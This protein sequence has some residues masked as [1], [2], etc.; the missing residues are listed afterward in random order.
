M[1]GL[2][3]GSWCY[4]EEQRGQSPGLGADPSGEGEEGGRRKRIAT[5]E[6]RTRISDT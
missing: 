6:E 3:I 1:A 5:H 2:V 4:W